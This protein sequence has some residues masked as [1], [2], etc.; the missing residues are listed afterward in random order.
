MPRRK[1]G[2]LFPLEVAIL[3]HGSAIQARDGR[4]YGFSLARSISESGESLT[5]HGTLY[6]ALGRMTDS[7]LLSSSWE[8]PATAEAEGRPRRRLYEVTAEG[9]TA[10]SRAVAAAA[11]SR[12][13]AANTAVT[14]IAGSIA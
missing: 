7:G 9:A 8:D 2:S 6:K 4:F 1:P 12:V 14:S 5:A 13:I 10:L 3:E 11:P